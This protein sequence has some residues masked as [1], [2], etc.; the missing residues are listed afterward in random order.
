MFFKN[1]NGECQFMVRKGKKRPKPATVQRPQTSA[2]KLWLFR[3][4]ALILIPTLLLGVLEAGLRLAGVGY[5]T[6]AIME[7]KIGGKTLCL[8]NTR[9]TWR[10]FPSQIAREFDSSLIFEKEKPARTFRIFTVGASAAM[11]IPEPMHNFGRYLEVMLSGLYPD[12]RFEVNNAAI[13]AVNSHV[14]RDIVR[15]CAGYDADLFIVYLGN[16]EVVGPFGPSTVFAQTPPALPLV[17]AH[18]AVKSTRIGQMLDGLIRSAADGDTPPKW[19]GLALFMDKQVRHDAD[20]M[21]AVYRNFEKNLRAICT[22][23]RDCGSAV[24]LSNVAVNLKDCP[25]FASLHQDG[26]SEAPMQ[27]WQQAWEQGC[28]DQAA[29]RCEQALE[30]YLT[31]AVIDETYA[32]LQ[33]RMGLCYWNLE[34]FESSRVHFQKAVQYDTLRFRADA[35]INETIRRVA[36]G[37]EQDAI[38]FANSVAAFEAASPN[39]T[40]GEE[41]FYEHVHMN[42]KGNYTLARALVPAV[43][44]VLSA[45]GMSSSAAIL[46]EVQVAERV[47]YT[48][49][50]H[51]YFLERMVKEMMNKPPFT[52]QLNHDEWMRE[53]VAQIN[54]LRQSCDVQECLRRYDAAIEAHPEDWRLLASQIPLRVQAG[55]KSDL[56]SVESQLRKIL[57]L[58][59][60]DFA[61]EGLGQNLFNQGRLGEAKDVLN[62]LLD[63]KPNDAF[64]HYL[65]GEIA[66]RQHDYAEAEKR[67]RRAIALAPTIPVTYIMLAKTYDETQATDKAVRVLNEALEI[68]SETK[69]AG[70]FHLQLGNIL[71]KAGDSKKALERM[72]TAFRIQPEYAENEDYKMLY[73]RIRS[74]LKR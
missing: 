3:L 63:L 12:I 47:A 28:T 13:T 50:E 38:Y 52:Q 2:A 69:D 55:E 67:G 33:Y 20:A 42:F 71:F 66:R 68:F 53:T 26:L 35:R 59:P 37:R 41:L 60:V 23:A 49:F 10:Y 57:H 32:E 16:N 40:V 9:F 29:G 62:Q 25:P 34:D 4:L 11:G 7:K 8:P 5:P 65:L 44:K 15:D 70:R 43:E 36:E 30:H 17:R 19:E 73:D 46:T 56:K 21:E 61:Y 22:T 1:L 6:R 72:D 74:A 27:A 64:A 14:V 39:G 48:D 45:K 31:A 24:V 54:R 18:L 58:C 51:A